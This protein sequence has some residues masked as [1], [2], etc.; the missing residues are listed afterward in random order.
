MK[1]YKR[2]VASISII[3]AMLLCCMPLV[4]ADV[5]GG[6][7]YSDCQYSRDC[8]ASSSAPASPTTSTPNSN[9]SNQQDSSQ[10]TSG[11][12]VILNNFDDYFT[13][14]GKQL[15]LT[16]DGVVY[17]YVVQNNLKEKHSVTILE[18]AAD[19]VTILVSSTPQR[20]T[21]RI[22]QS[23][24]FD[25]TSDKQNDIEIALKSI[26]EGKAELTFKNLQQSAL[27]TASMP[28][29]TKKQ[30]SSWI[31]YAVCLAVGLSLFLAL[32]LK[33]R[34]HNKAL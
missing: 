10:S 5:Y 9:S 4:Q 32:Y 16:K 25:V 24:A 28:Q 34:P 15:T 11:A 20:A 13:D 2:L 21:M 26:N 22:G 31:I 8:P 29:Q 19:T 7:N 30:D 17:F 27:R 23:E 1:T 33:R 12:E 6:S 14:S 3:V 18:V